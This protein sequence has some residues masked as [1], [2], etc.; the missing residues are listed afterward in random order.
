MALN[1]SPLL[2]SGSTDLFSAASALPGL[3]LQNSNAQSANVESAAVRKAKAQFTT[4]VS[5]PPWIDRTGRPVSSP[6]LSAVK[7]MKS[8]VDPRASSTLP[9]D[10][11][12]GFT[13]YRAL[14]RLQV[15]ASAATAKTLP[16][17]ERQTLDQAFQ[18]GLVDLRGYLA[19]VNPDK[20]NLY[21]DNPSRLA[22][23]A[24]APRSNPGGSRFLGAAAPTRTAELLT[25]DGIE[26]ISL[27]AR[28]NN[29][30]YDIR[31]NIAS[32]QGPVTLD[33][34]ARAL[35][36]KVAD[37]I[38]LDSNGKKL[39]D[40]AGNFVAAL[41]SRF[42]VTS[43]NGKWGLS[44]STTP[45]ETLWATPQTV[46]PGLMVVA[47]RTAGMGAG[48]VEVGRIDDPKGT[49]AYRAAAS[50]S[51]V[52]T[53]GTARAKLISKNAA[54]KQSPVDVSGA[55]TD[56]DGNTY[57]LGTTAGATEDV[58][59]AGRPE[60]FLRKVAPSGALLWQRPIWTGNTATATAISLGADGRL[61]V[62]G[63][64]REGAPGTSATNGDIFV[65]RFDAGGAELMRKTIQKVGNQQPSSVT[66]D[67]SGNVYV[68]S[69]DGSTGSSLIKLDASGKV[70][71]SV[72]KSSSQITSIHD[73][74]DGTVLMLARGGDGQS[75]LERLD[76]K[77]A[78]TGA[79]LDLN[80]LQPADIAISADGQIA[81]SGTVYGSGGDKDAV[82]SLID[83]KLTSESR[84]VIGTTG[85]EEADSLLFTDGYLYV[86]GRTTGTLGSFQRGKVDGFVSRI[87]PQTAQLV[88]T[89]QFGKPGATTA[90]V[91][92]ARTT[93]SSAA[94]EKIGLGTGQLSPVID[95]HLVDTTRLRAGDNFQVALN[96]GQLRKITV[97][98]DETVTTLADKVRKALGRR[99]TVT[100]TTSGM[101]MTLRIQPSTGYA[102][103]L[104]AGAPGQDALSKLGLKPA[105]L[106]AAPPP[107]ANA[108]A[109][110]PGGQ[111]GLGLADFLALDTPENAKA[112][113]GKV[114]A[115]VSMTKTA[116]RSLYWDDTKAAKVAG[117]GGQTGLNALQTAQLQQYRTAIARLGG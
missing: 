77:L 91:A 21:F 32:I 23:S 25:L 50:I 80:D 82:V 43:Q 49:A 111:Y 45:G 65:A 96:G 71:A 85:T 98:Q 52:D 24:I 100:A 89:T 92:L 11:R 33:K 107:A 62:A 51:A 46:E 59:A 7:A 3:L 40:S 27:T 53:A 48:T 78:A 30:S 34:V 112:A 72:S 31:V 63:T 116:Y 61:T 38:A 13:A 44:L 29:I 35:N 36:D 64:V 99:V 20:L 57:L 60:M 12:S 90:P 58:T 105:R 19:S 22:V 97:A 114:Q 106:Y 88:G 113:L 95:K 67:A 76:G 108:P 4:P 26:E 39:K 117:A 103:Q 74:G 8:V 115:A 47:G 6:S 86:G 56:A 79:L 110:T 68:A 42:S 87:D 41:S 109:V 69:R 73:A 15:L 10:L 84:V 81:V 14:D 75:Y 93:T 104:A 102:V 17:P 9:V 28:K 2:G 16:A 55:V 70:I 54:E 5:L 83:S 66:A 1:L 18:K 101:G 94:L 37:V